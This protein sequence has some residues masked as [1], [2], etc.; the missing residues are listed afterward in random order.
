MRQQRAARAIRIDARVH[1][2]RARNERIEHRRRHWIAPLM[3]R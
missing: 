1:S 3:A 2:S